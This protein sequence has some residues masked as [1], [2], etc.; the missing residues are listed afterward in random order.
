MIKKFFI[1]FLTV[2]LVIACS[3]NNRDH[4]QEQFELGKQMLAGDG[5]TVP[6]TLHA[7]DNIRMAAEGGNAD[8]MYH[9]GY[10]SQYGIGVEKNTDVALDWYE[11]SANAGFSLAQNKMG[12]IY[13]TGNGEEQDYAT[14]LAW[15]TKSARNG[16]D[17]A[18][19]MLGKMYSIGRGMEPDTA[20]AIRW[21]KKSVKGGH[22]YPEFLLGKL[23]YE[24]GNP[25]EAYE[26]VKKSADQGVGHAKELL[27][28][29]RQ[30]IDN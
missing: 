7:I 23:L 19:Y 1:L 26:W 29:I 8:A 25:D 28:E 5:L 11:R 4:L 2:I 21:L 22:P 18:Q 30:T 3:T 20:K 15:F 10:Y 12:M 24:T 9:M 27:E 13:Y 16:Y 6:D 17:Q 14:A